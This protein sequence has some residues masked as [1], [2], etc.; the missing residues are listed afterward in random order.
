MG[1]CTKL[2]HQLTR[3]PLARLNMEVDA[4]IL[5]VIC[6]GVAVSAIN[7]HQNATRQTMKKRRSQWTREIL[8]D[9]KIF[10]VQNALI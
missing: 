3:H 5:L 6:I 7:A 10:G 4:D 1:K 8:Q 9:R 2:L